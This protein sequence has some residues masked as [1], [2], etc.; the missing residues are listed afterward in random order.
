MNEYVITKQELRKWC[1][2]PAE[3]L[4]E[5]PDRKM[6][7]VVNADKQALQAQIGNM[8]ADEVIANNQAGKSTVWVLPGGPFGI[9]DTLVERVNR[10]KISLKKV[11]LIHMDTWLDWDYRL[12]PEENL[13]FSCKGKMLKNFY[14]KIDPELTVPEEQR[15]F[16][17]PRDPDRFDIVVEQQGGVDTV[18]GGVGCKGLVAFNEAPHDFYHH[19]TVEEYAHLKSRCVHMNEDTIIAYAEREFGACFEALPP[20]AFTV[21]MKSMLSAKRAL[22]I[23][24]TGSWKETIV[25]IAMFSEPTTEYPVTFFPHYVPKCVLFC[26]PKTIDHEISRKYLDTPI[27]K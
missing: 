5:H 15:Y 2:I 14:A 16:P 20:N 11:H 26:D 21:G 18:V 4:A 1:S 10:E 27:L 22:F 19:I 23:V 24:T 12:F 9:F 3:E 8:L 7:L 13:R 25:R 6:D 17:D